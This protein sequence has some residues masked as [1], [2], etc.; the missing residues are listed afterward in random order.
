MMTSLPGTAD[1]LPMIPEIFVCSAAFMLLL[2]DLFIS[3]QRRGLVHFLSLLV[4]LAAAILTGR[5][6][7]GPTI[8]VFGDMFIRDYA[9]DVMKLAM[10]AVTG[11][12]LIYGRSYM[13]ERGLLKGE[14]YPIVL[15]A[16]LGM[17]ILVSAGNMVTIYLGLEL[18]ALS[19][20]GLV[21]IDRDSPRGAEAAM[22]YFVLGALASGMLLYGMSMIY[23][24][25]GTLDLGQVFAASASS[26]DRSLLLFGVV[27]VIVGI[28]FKLG[29]APF[30]MWVPDV[31]QGAPTAITM[32]IG[33]VPKIAA[34]G[35]AYRLLEQGV[36]PVSEYWAE[37]L[38]ALAALSL[39]IG[40]VLAI[41]QTN[42]KRMLAY[43]TISHVGFLLMGLIAATPAAYSASLFYAISYAIMAI[44]AFG[45]IIVLSRKGFEAEELSD[46]RGLWRQQPVHAVLILMVMASLAGVPPFLGFWA[47]LAVIGS[48]LAGGYMWLAILAVIAAVVGA[49]YYLRVIKL[50]FFDEPESSL[51]PI[52]ATSQTRL[53]FAVN[54]L[55]LLALGLFSDPLMEM[56][57][58]AFSA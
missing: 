35:M 30:H 34:F 39:V 44:A 22:K 32:L 40:N 58:V 7:A 1:L 47:K 21:A 42:L 23:G 48:A 11:V 6:M 37:A 29:A 50:M 15:F 5:E 38:S 45:A 43:S 26:G 41:A 16:L 8:S 56:C 49:F 14:F 28:G 27:F 53:V 20:Y 24:A 2:V 33:S 18:L 17:M 31:Y 55:S 25:T 57:K 3:P 46:Y 4:L 13:N 10:Y 12:A 51:P 19:S 52:H 36:G 54:C 9:A